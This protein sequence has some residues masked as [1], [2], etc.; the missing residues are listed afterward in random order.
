[1]D[2]I[3][4]FQSVGLSHHNIHQQ[5]IYLFFLQDIKGLATTSSSRYCQ[6]RQPFGKRSL[7]TS[8][9]IRF[10]INNKQLWVH[11]RFP[12]HR[13]PPFCSAAGEL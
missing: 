9:Q 12:I 11:L 7:Q 5:Q 3:Q 6:F 13:V 1:M 8:E 4:Y 10:V 2:L